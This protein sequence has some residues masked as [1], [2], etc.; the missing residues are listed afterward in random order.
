MG[1][2]SADKTRIRSGTAQRSRKPRI[3]SRSPCRVAAQQ[4]ERRPESSGFSR[5]A[6]QSF[7]SRNCLDE[8]L[9]HY[10]AELW[11]ATPGGTH[12]WDNPALLT[13]DTTWAVEARW[14]P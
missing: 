13:E 5:G 8:Y 9:C 11:L 14:A 7:E 1:L 3:P 10:Y 12:T 4:R 2:W 6:S